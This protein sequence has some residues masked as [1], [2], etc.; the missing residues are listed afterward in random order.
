MFTKRKVMSAVIVVVV[1]I[2]TFLASM[3]SVF[4]LDE[5][6]QLN[7]KD[8]VE[9]KESSKENVMESDLKSDDEVPNEEKDYIEKEDDLEKNKK[10][11]KEKIKNEKEDKKD[12]GIIVVYKDIEKADR[13]K[14]QISSKNNISQ[15]KSNKLSKRHNIEKIEFGSEDK[16]E[17]VLEDLNNNPDVLYAQPDYSLETFVLPE[18]EH[19]NQQWA[20]FNDGQEIE[21]INGTAGIDINIQDAWEITYGEEDVI[22]AVIDTGVDIE[23]SDINESIFINVNEELNGED[24]DN[25][26]LIDDIN[27][28]D[29]ANNDNSVYDSSIYDL[30]G[31]HISGAIAA[32]L[33]EEG[34]AGIA[35]N[36][37]ILPVKFME[38][39]TGSTSDAIK[40]IEYASDMGASIFSCS[41]GS[42]HYNQALKDVIEQ[43]EGLFIFAAGNF[44]QDT[45]IEPVY[46]AAYDLDNIILARYN[47]FGI[48]AE[49][50]GNETIVYADAFTN[51]NLVLEKNRNIK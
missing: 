15:I 18:E 46:P 48:E 3:G 1:I 4:A 20:L 50:Y 33:N 11:D 26:D 45:E 22:V 21:G 31:T 27:G 7:P 17:L 39:N 37:K 8:Y 47:G 43:T 16:L 5:G 6:E 40:A 41:W 42:L 35:P 30:H 49:R 12:N 9:E 51:Y 38:E 14:T 10:D 29:F 19:F 34:I 28:W 36:V 23:H 25:N 44:A 32:S 2:N 13:V 24:T